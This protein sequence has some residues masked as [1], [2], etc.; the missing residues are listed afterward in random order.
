VG[1]ITSS[2]STTAAIAKTTVN[3]ENQQ[4]VPLLA[5]S[6]SVREP[7]KTQKPPPAVGDLSRKH[8]NVDQDA[9]ESHPKPHKDNKRRTVQ[10]EYVAPRTQTQRGEPSTAAP[11]SGS[12]RT[13]AR[14]GSGGPVEVQQPTTRRTVS[15]EKP[16]P[17]DPPVARDAKYSGGGQPSSSQR[18][19][20]MPPPARP[21]RGPPRSVSDTTQMSHL[22]G[23]PVSMARPNTGGS[24]TSTGSRSGA[25]PTR[26]SYSQPVAPTVAGTNAQGRMSQPKNGKSYNISAP[27]MQDEEEIRR[28]NAQVPAKFARVAGFAEPHTANEQKGHKRSNTISSFFRTNSVF[29]KSSRK[30]SS[31]NQD[32][33]GPAE[34]P[35]KSYPPVSMTGAVTQGQMDTPR[36]S[37]DSRRSISFGFGKKRSGSI[38]GSQTTLQDKPRRFSFLP[39]SISLKSIG[40]GKDF[41]APEQ[42]DQ[43]PDSR[44]NYLE[45]PMTA[46]TDGSRNVSGALPTTADGSYD[47]SRDSPLQDRRGTSTGSPAQHQRYAS[48]GQ[49]SDP[50]SGAPPQF[51]P[52]LNFRQGE[53]TLTTESESSLNDLQI[54]RG[55]GAYPPGFNDYDID[56]RPTNNSRGGNGRGVLQKNNRKFTEAYEQDANGYGP[57]HVDSAGSSSAARKVMDFF[58][59]RGRDRGG[60]Q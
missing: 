10:V 11:A 33:K 24:M 38:S 23:P 41:P 35:K 9:T 5:R 29:G 6:A 25:L 15:T 18:Q 60:E 12:S 48:H 4:E 46:R 26:G 56:R 22:A 27:M 14:A 47:R 1:F 17:Q 57:T 3:S 39:G 42:Y 55:P 34:K 8:G 28:P 21:G 2:A 43:R 37:M 50:R 52:P 20:G 36:Q 7:S 58:R 44:G 49:T 13:R 51:L 19:Q 54:R 30:E 31:A 53:S 16:L 32:S 59:R 40:I 45:P